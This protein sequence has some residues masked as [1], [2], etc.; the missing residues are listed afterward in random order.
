MIGE[1]SIAG[2]LFLALPVVLFIIGLILK[3][4]DRMTTNS[5]RKS[6]EENTYYSSSIYADIKKQM[7][8][9]EQQKKIK[10]IEQQTAEEK[11]K[12]E[13]DE[14]KKREDRKL[15]E[16]LDQE[17]YRQK[18]L[19]KQQWD[20][21]ISE[22]NRQIVLLEKSLPNSDDLYCYIDGAQNL[23]YG[24]VCT[25]SDIER[26]IRKNIKDIFDLQ[27]ML[28]NKYRHKVKQ[29][30]A[31]GNGIKAGDQITTVREYLNGHLTIK[32]IGVNGLIVENERGDEYC[33][34]YI[35]LCG[36]ILMIKRAQD[37]IYMDET[38]YLELIRTVLNATLCNST[39][40][41][42]TNI[43][44]RHCIINVVD[45]N[46]YHLFGYQRDSKYKAYETS[47]TNAIKRYEKLPNLIHSYLLIKMF[48]G[49]SVDLYEMSSSI[50]RVSGDWILYYNEYNVDV[51]LVI[52]KEYPKSFLVYENKEGQY[53]NNILKH[54][55]KVQIL[56]VSI[57][58]IY[59]NV[60]VD[61]AKQAQP[62]LQNI[63]YNIGND[64]EF[65][66]DI[67]CIQRKVLH[68]LTSNRQ[69]FNRLAK[70]SY[71]RY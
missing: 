24:G 18:S 51:L 66:N 39:I 2:I 36:Q 14:D 50:G 44:L 22:L 52:E 3:T 13:L 54:H 60:K 53:A 17:F 20:E 40:K 25:H 31:K 65:F 59:S 71:S 47:N 57:N 61:I 16:R 38:K 10:E 56:D 4:Y 37:I 62:C 63:Y 9:D 23:Y 64:R 15:Q 19:D 29:Y 5:S 11:R 26:Q 46:I 33:I 42:T 21:V 69:G 45:K 41:I 67:L 35:D 1:Y 34:G 12:Q 55:R 68:L 7:D 6:S 43:P 32:E 28:S 48:S 49:A 8:T 70:V 27:S 58:R 30:F